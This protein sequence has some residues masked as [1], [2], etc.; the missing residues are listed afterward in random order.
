ML[1][2]HIIVCIHSNFVGIILVRNG[3]V[4]SNLAILLM[5]HRADIEPILVAPQ[6]PRLL[7][8]ISRRTAS[9]HRC[10]SKHTRATVGI[11]TLTWVDGGEG[12]GILIILAQVKMST[13][14]TLDAAMLPHE[15]DELATILFI[16][17]VEPAASVDDV[18]LLQHPQTGAIGR[19]V[20][21]DKYLP[22]LVGGMVD[23]KV[24]E[25]CNLLVVDNHLVAGVGGVAKDC[26]AETDNV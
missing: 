15:L 16:G 5:V 19:S 23:Q 22:P 10:L 21:K 8:T 2:R 1:V 6:K 11:R 18:I 13:E 20:R 26:G 3:S 25:P 24:F 7:P 9:H 4:Q 12:N 17:M 14:P